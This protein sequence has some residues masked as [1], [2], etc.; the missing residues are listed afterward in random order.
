[1][2]VLRSHEEVG[3]VTL[4]GTLKPIERASRHAVDSV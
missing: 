4:K 2:V 1:M 3:H